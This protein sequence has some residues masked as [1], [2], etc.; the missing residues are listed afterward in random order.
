MKKTDAIYYCGQGIIYRCPECYKVDRAPYD[1]APKTYE[2]R[3][4]NKEFEM[5]S[6]SDMTPD[7]YKVIQEINY[8]ETGTIYGASLEM[9]ESDNLVKSGKSVGVDVIGSIPTKPEKKNWRTS[10]FAPWRIGKEKLREWAKTDEG[11]EI[12]AE[13][14]K[15]I[16]SPE[17][18]M[19]D[20]D[21]KPLPKEVWMEAKM[22]VLMKKHKGLTNDQKIELL[23]QEGFTKDNHEVYINKKGHVEVFFSSTIAPECDSWVE[24]K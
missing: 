2:C 13:V 6:K 1:H 19:Q 21:D 23:K 3:F 22:I 24:W 5:V 4:C 14:K 15:L 7:L 10:Y 17:T 9:L 18:F 12:I 11:K 16:I 20:D 8:L